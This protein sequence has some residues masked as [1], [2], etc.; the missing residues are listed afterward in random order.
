M[1]LRG[2]LEQCNALAEVIITGGRRRKKTIMM[3]D[4][5]G[6]GL[7]ENR[8]NEGPDFDGRAGGHRHNEGR[9]FERRVG[10]ECG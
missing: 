8:H 3:A 10:G 1:L 4:V 7:G 6:G 2:R 9:E 5:W